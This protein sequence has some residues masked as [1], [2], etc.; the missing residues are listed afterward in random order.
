MSP[1]E[2]A[3]AFP[4]LPCFTAALFVAFGAVGAAVPGAA[5]DVVGNLPSSDYNTY[6]A[7]QSY[8]DWGNE[9]CIAVN[10]TNPQEMIISTFGFGSWISSATAQLWYSTNGGAGWAIR[11]SVPAPP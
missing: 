4:L 6:I 2:R 11:F 9:P 7:P 5:V 3:V 10:P 8:R 1:F